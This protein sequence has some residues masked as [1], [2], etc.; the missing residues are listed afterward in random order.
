MGKIPI[1]MGLYYYKRDNNV[2][3]PAKTLKEVRQFLDA[4]R[5]QISQENILFLAGDERAATLLRKLSIEY[6]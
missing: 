1:I 6:S 3:F 4:N 2:S 5:S